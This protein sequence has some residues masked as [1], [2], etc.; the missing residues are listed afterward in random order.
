MIFINKW[1]PAM[2]LEPMLTYALSELPIG[3]E[4]R[5]PT[6]LRCQGV[7]RTQV[8]KVVLK[9]LRRSKPHVFHHKSYRTKHLVRKIR[10]TSERSVIPTAQDW[11]MK[12]F[13]CGTERKPEVGI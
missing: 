9:S 11:K 13:R 2:T 7:V 1:K 5:K 4:E 10:T 6:W 12:T 8:Q 3:S